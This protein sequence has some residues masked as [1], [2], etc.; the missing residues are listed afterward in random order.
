MQNIKYRK[1]NFFNRLTN[2]IDSKIIDGNEYDLEVSSNKGINYYRVRVFDR[3]FEAEPIALTKEEFFSPNTQNNCQINEI[4]SFF[5]TKFYQSEFD[6]HEEFEH[7]KRISRSKGDFQL[8]DYYN[9]LKRITQKNILNS[10]IIYDFRIPAVE[11]R[12]KLG[13]ESYNVTVE[14]AR[15]YHNIVFLKENV[16]KGFTERNTTIY[17][18]FLRKEIERRIKQ[19]ENRVLDLCIENNYPLILSELVFVICSGNQKLIAELMNKIML[20]KTKKDVALIL[21]DKL[22]KLLSP[23]FTY[24]KYLEV[25]FLNFITG[26]QEDISYDFVRKR[27]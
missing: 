12:K 24:D 18:I 15:N 22:Y 8:P 23:S 9:F 20:A 25:E 6:Y 1:G 11:S 7:L 17:N 21:Y 27:I 5:K 14:N 10:H 3:K 26:N 4:T 19:T 13:I 2:Q 16:E